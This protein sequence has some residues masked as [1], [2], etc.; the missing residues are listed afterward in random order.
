MQIG[1]VFDEIQEAYTKK[2]IRWV[3]HYLDLIKMLDTSFPKQWHPESILDLGAGNGNITASLIKHYPDATYTLLDASAKML[4]EAK[5]RFPETKV[6][7]QQDL[8]Q[9]AQFTSGTFSLVT[10]SFSLHHLSLS[11]KEN[12]I[13]SIHKWLSPGGYFAYIDLFISKKDIEHAPFMASW[14]NFVMQEG[15]SEDWEYLANH[16]Q[17]YDKPDN[18]L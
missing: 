16:Y 7:Y 12:T 3:P 14:Q 5:S 17:E 1:Q 11:D 4:E 15:D 10:A 9:N 18:L 6:F 13:K 2:M 8:I